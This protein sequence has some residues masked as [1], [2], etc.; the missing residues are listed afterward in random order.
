MKKDL[1]SSATIASAGTGAPAVRIGLRAVKLQSHGVSL[2]VMRSLARGDT[3]TPP[4]GLYRGSGLH[5]A[6]D[7]TFNDRSNRQR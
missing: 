2:D 5:G 4:V 3:G 6:P 7:P 1:R